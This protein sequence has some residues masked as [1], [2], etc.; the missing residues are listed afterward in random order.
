MIP[1][2]N[3]AASACAAESDE[4]FGGFDDQLVM[5]LKFLQ[6]YFLEHSVAHSYHSVYCIL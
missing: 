6:Q 1:H 2:E 4:E 5:L 3:E